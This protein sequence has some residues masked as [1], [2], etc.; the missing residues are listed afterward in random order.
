MAVTRACSFYTAIF[1]KDPTLI[2]YNS[3]LTASE[4]N[5]IKAA[6]KTVVYDN[7]LKWHIGEFDHLKKESCQ[8][9]STPNEIANST[10]NSLNLKIYPNPNSGVFRI[11]GDAPFQVEVFN[12]QGV[13]ILAHQSH[14][15][16]VLE[17][18]LSAHSKG[19][20]LVSTTVGELVQHSKIVI[21]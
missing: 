2:T 21:Q 11:S 20:Y 4:A 12:L 17:L 5:F 7:L 1:R 8:P 19:I 15:N 3:T 14:E 16:E 18:D 9:S 10:N 6:T 13:K